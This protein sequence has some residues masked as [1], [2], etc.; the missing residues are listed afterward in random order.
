MGTK[1]GNDTEIWK[2]VDIRNCL[3]ETKKHTKKVGR[4]LDTANTHRLAVI[5][6]SQRRIE[7]NQ[8]GTEIRE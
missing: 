2:G 3:V 5:F 6:Y 7:Y 1:I 4:N 8:L